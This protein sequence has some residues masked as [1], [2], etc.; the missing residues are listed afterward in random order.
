MRFHNTDTDVLVE[1]EVLVDVDLGSTLVVF[2]DEVNT[3]D[4]VIKSLIEICGHTQEQAEQCA[5]IIHY[6]GK[7][8]VKEGDRKALEPLKDALNDRG[9]SAAVTDNN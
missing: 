7:Y 6:H 3:F 8:G 4:W 5:L 9:I 2:N 1:E